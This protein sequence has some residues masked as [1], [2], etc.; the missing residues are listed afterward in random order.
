MRVLIVGATGL[1][2]KEVVRMLSPEHQVIRASRSG[3]DL[4]VDLTDKA[5]IVSMYQR[6]GTVDAVICVAGAAKFAPLETLSDDDFA[7]SLAN[8]L[9]GQ[10][11]LV[12]RA[13][14]HIVQGGSLTL[15]SGILAQHPMTGSAAVSIV[16]AGIEAF[17]RSAALE[18]RGK[19]RVNV[20]SPGW[21]SETLAAM[22]QARSAG[23]PAEA[24]AQAYK[25]CLLEDIT[26]EVIQVAKW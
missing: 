6:L 1:L 8:K 7:F 24:V 21:V 25:R 4:S 17:G 13:V 19:A 3:P 9:M 10:V 23:V 11:N 5:S 18:L 22:G 12:R 14:G 2:G 15:T 26:G 16:N 20:V